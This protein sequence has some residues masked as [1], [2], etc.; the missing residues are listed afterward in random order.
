MFT[1]IVEALGTVRHAG[2]GRIEVEAAMAASLRPGDSVSVNGA[3]LTVTS[4]AGQ[5]FSADVMPETLRRTGLDTLRDG[6]PVNLERALAAGD[7]LGGHIVSGHVD[8][9]GTVYALRDESNARLVVISAPAS[10]LPMI[11]TKGSVAV[12]GISLTVV[13]VEGSRFSVSLIPHTLRSTTAGAW[14]EGS[15]VNLEADIVARYVRRLLD[16]AAPAAVSGLV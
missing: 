16:A 10:L 5:R 11:A 15:V 4:A 9:T 8:G 14:V 1:G 12:D 13:D 2:N 3:C 7:R 6:S